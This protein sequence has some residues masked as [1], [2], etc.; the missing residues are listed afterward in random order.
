MPLF[1]C[2]NASLNTIKPHGGSDNEL[3]GTRKD[4][5]V[6]KQALLQWGM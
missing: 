3:S 6:P 1:K 4:M 5:I 2:V